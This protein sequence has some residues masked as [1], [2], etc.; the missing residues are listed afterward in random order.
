MFPNEPSAVARRARYVLAATSVLLA[1]AALRLWGLAS[2]P[3]AL[4]FD[5]AHN[6][7]DAARFLDGLRPLFLPDNGGR[8]VLL[9]WLHAPLLA[10]LGRANPE[11]ALRFVSAAVGLLTIALL[12]PA[13]GRLLDA[14]RVGL[15]AGAYLALSYWHLHF[16]RYGI[17]AIL[18]PLWATGAVLAW[19]RAIGGPPREQGGEEARASVPGAASD[20]TDGPSADARPG[21]R[22]ADVGRP[23]RPWWA[24]AALCGVMLAGAVWSHPSGRLLPFVLVLHG[25]WRLGASWRAG[26]ADWGP[27]KALAVAGLVS[28]LLFAP[29]GLHFW[30]H[31]WLFTSH[32][33]DVSLAAVAEAD[34]GG[35]VARAL[36]G[37]AEAV[38]G[39]FFLE[40]DPSTFHNLPG[41]PVFD[42]LSAVLAVL[43]L[44][45][46]LAALLGW[47]RPGRTRADRDRAALLAVWLGVMLLP[48]LL[49]DRPPNYSRAIAALPVIVALPALGMDWALRRA[50]P[51]VPY[52]WRA[53]ALLGVFLF[54]GGW[55]AWSY[56][57]RFAGLEHL[58]ASYDLDK[59]EA[60]AAL[61][62]LAQE[63]TVFL[64]PL[65]A[66][67]AT[68]AYFNE[69]ARDADAPPPIRTLDGRQTLVLPG[70][71]RDAIVAFPAEESEEEN[72]AGRAVALL[73]APED[74]IEVLR[75]GRDE[76]L[77]EILRVPASA[78][79]DAA[80]PTDAPLEPAVW[81]D[82][83]FA[84]A[85]DLLGFT[86]GEARAGE[87]LPVTLVWRTL[88][89]LDEDYTVFVHLRGPDGEGWG[90]DD[91][92]PGRASY[93]TSAWQP[94][95]I[96]VDRYRP[97]LD[98]AAEGEVRVCLGWYERETLARLPLGDGGDEICSRPLPVLPAAPE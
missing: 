11:L 61:E 23:P 57:Q 46:A 72:L 66:E 24:W 39:M 37:Q 63:A 76:P 7:I 51:R 18:A 74:A 4:Q 25:L 83:R 89:P 30:T 9:T 93:R 43:G 50:T 47:G 2:L 90:G 92:E 84:G 15:L 32:A 56:F 78:I 40:G 80:P 54:A 17:R 88:E 8:E 68:I 27:I 36:A 34:H 86:L 69:H 41:L 35:S 67:Q 73:G 85:I 79:G 64:A 31:P 59:R 1:A 82:A 52:G 10:A 44:G 71:G 81:T 98:E 42:P 14:R 5:E 55:T 97:R 26:R 91:R 28:L 19:W 70:D 20:E 13:L 95:D 45:V 38:A 22:T 6:A 33:S 94:G 58:A 16:S 96:I 75:D 53:A 21:G 60:L 65:W 77:L 48:T 12:M 87:R 49:S 3:P 62:D 29:L